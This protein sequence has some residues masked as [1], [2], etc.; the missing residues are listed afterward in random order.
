RADAGE[1]DDLDSGQGAPRGLGGS[2]AVIVTVLLSRLSTYFRYAAARVVTSSMSHS[3]PK[4]PSMLLPDLTYVRKG[5]GP[6][7]VLLHGIGHNKG[8]WDPIIDEL[9]ERYDVIAPDLSGFGE[10]PAFAGGVAY[11]MPNAVEHLATQ[12]DVWG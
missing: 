7:L 9:A 1:L 6:A 4:G 5:S 8:A 11:T 10:S 12:F 2:H 3:L